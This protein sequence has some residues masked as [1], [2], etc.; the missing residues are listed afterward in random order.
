MKKLLVLI[1]LLF[2]V[3]CWSDTVTVRQP[4]CKK[5]C[6]DGT[7]LSCQ[8]FEGTG[9]DN[10]EY[11]VTEDGSSGGV[12]NPD[13]TT[14]PGRGS[15]SLRVKDDTNVGTYAV[16]KYGDNTGVNNIYG[17]FRIKLIDLPSGTYELFQTYNIQGDSFPPDSIEAHDMIWISSTGVLQ[18][19]CNN[20]ETF[21]GTTQLST[22]TWY[23]VWYYIARSTNSDG[24]GWVKVSTIPFIP[25]ANEI[26]YSGGEQ[27]GCSYTKQNAIGFTTM[28]GMG[29]E[30]LIDQ[31]IVSASAI[32]TICAD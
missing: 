6:T 28:H 27:G 22:G 13:Y 16:H 23:Y 3:P 24:N 11:W 26:T 19:H 14:D 12:I 29:Y 31:S 8:N 9:F 1:L 15:Q 10:S 21:N 30:Y 2:A 18:I 20:G 32:G 7:F 4:S 25:E 17:F 5:A